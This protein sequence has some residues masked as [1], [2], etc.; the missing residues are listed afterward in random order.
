M[1]R[2]LRDAVDALIRQSERTIYV[3]YVDEDSSH[4]QVTRALRE[5]GDI[6]DTLPRLAIA[7]RRQLDLDDQREY[8]LAQR[9]KAAQPTAIEV[10]P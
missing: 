5:V 1:N 10:R 6:L 8:E 7:A 3:E 9:A 2:E 4:A